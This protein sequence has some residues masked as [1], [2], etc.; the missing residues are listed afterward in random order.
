[1][2]WKGHLLWDRSN[3]P[4][5]SWAVRLEQWVSHPTSYNTLTTGIPREPFWEGGAPKAAAAPAASWG[6]SAGCLD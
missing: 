5:Q 4:G 1:M 2:E 6:R 3:L